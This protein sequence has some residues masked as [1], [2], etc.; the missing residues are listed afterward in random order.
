VET[1][2]KTTAPDGLSIDELAA[3]QLDAALD[4][5]AELLRD[6]VD[7]GAA[8]GFLPPLAAQDARSYWRDVAAAVGQGARVVLVARRGG[9]VVGSVQLDLP[10][11]PNARHR[12]EVQKL[13]VHSAARGQ[14]IGRRLMAAVEEAARRRG[15]TLLV[16][17]TRQG[18]IAERLYARHGYIRAGEIPHYAES[19]DGTLH[20]TVLFY[21]VLE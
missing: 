2:Q 20:T 11:K 16:L 3:G 9:Q 15:R 19:A 13:L 6:S 7:G 5:L 21:R 10:G 12:A 8:V 4:E 14:G 17:D 1:F 18:D